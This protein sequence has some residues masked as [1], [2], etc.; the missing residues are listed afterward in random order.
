MIQSAVNDRNLDNN[1]PSLALLKV[2]ESLIAQ[3]SILD[4]DCCEGGMDLEEDSIYSIVN[5]YSSIRHFRFDR[6]RHNQRL[7][8]FEL[9]D[10]KEFLKNPT[11]KGIWQLEASWKNDSGI[12]Q[13]IWEQFST[14][15]EE[16]HTF[17]ISFGKRKVEV[18]LDPSKKENYKEIIFN[19]LS[20]VF[21]TFNY[22][23]L[24]RNKS[25][26]RLEIGGD[27]YQVILEAIDFEKIARKHSD[28]IDFFERNIYFENFLHSIKVDTPYRTNSGLIFLSQSIAKT[29]KVKIISLQPKSLKDLAVFLEGVGKIEN[30]ILRP[31]FSPEEVIFEPYFAFTRAAS[32]EII[33]DGRLI[34]IFL[35]AFE[36]F[37]G[38]RYSNA[39]SNVGQIAEDYLAQVYETLFRDTCPKGL[40]LGQLVDAIHNQIRIE[41]KSE[42]LIKPNLI[43]IY[44]EI[45][46][47]LKHPRISN[48]KTVTLIRELVNHI[49]A[50]MEYND[51]RLDIIL[52]KNPEFTIFPK[53]ILGNLTELIR[54]RNAAS[55]KTRVPLG[56]YEAL[57]SLYC[58]ISTKMW[59]DDAISSIDWEN[60]PEE[61]IDYLVEEALKKT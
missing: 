20:F 40:T 41:R 60:K 37:E 59:W 11:R 26:D 57:K 32:D 13:E 48:K 35:R 23:V 28:Q 45:K 61:I 25:S 54:N 31:I 39:I 3:R 27:E 17:E 55:H 50:L 12:S 1:N 9:V 16:K 49:A 21:Y 15:L 34:P 46:D 6:D 14:L 33:E 58:L 10:I 36:D 24:I 19:K 8:T 53:Q 5:S 18:T 38:K 47:L 2:Y 43:G 30:Q 56:E 22:A 7:R 42:I 44:S 52:G 29:K 4:Y 51:S